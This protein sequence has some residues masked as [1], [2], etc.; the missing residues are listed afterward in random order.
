MQECLEL[1]KVW[2]LT[3]APLSC[4]RA[5]NLFLRVWGYV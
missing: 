2:N 3:D 4:I 1:K 5:M